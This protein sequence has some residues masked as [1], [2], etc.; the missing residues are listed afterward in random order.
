MTTRAASA[1][2]K[3]GSATRTSVIAAPAAADEE[4]Y[5]N[6][7][8]IDE[9]GENYIDETDYRTEHD[10]W[11]TEAEQPA[12]TD[13][14]LAPQFEYAASKDEENQYQ[15]S[16]KTQRQRQQRGDQPKG[17]G[18]ELRRKGVNQDRPRRV[19]YEDQPEGVNGEE[20]YKRAPQSLSTNNKKQV[21]QLSKPD[22]KLTFNQQFEKNSPVIRRNEHFTPPTARYVH[23]SMH[24]LNDKSDRLEVQLHRFEQKQALGKPL[25]HCEKFT[26]YESNASYESDEQKINTTPREFS[27]FS[28]AEP[29]PQRK[30]PNNRR[31][32]RSKKK[33]QMSVS[34]ARRRER[35]SGEESDQPV[36]HCSKTFNTTS[37]PAYQNEPYSSDSESQVY[38]DTTEDASSSSRV[39]IPTFDGENWI[40]FIVQFETASRLCGWTTEVKRMRLILALREAALK[41]IQSQDIGNLTYKQLVKKLD[42]RFCTTKSRREVM[43]TLLGMKRQ[44]K[45]SILEFADQLRY[46]AKTADFTQEERDT[47]LY[48]AF[49]KGIE[50]DKLTQIEVFNKCLP[51]SFEEA[52]TI[53]MEYE[54]D[55]SITAETRQ[56]DVSTQVNIDSDSTQSTAPEDPKSAPKS[57]YKYNSHYR[58]SQMFLGKGDGVRSAWQA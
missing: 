28:S 35:F 56:Q 2:K 18:S 14:E 7:D 1:L 4:L 38:T 51:L 11:E 50:Y 58:N 15:E 49:M 29:F 42:A 27:N 8:T 5:Y 40:P 32:V 37:T 17:K 3:Q 16:S 30:P 21:Q 34:A 44:P 33:R 41:T 36:K 12:E 57:A 10:D 54:R 26:N 13:A 48:C 45:H 46:A 23:D 53:A 52:V 6:Q 19:N 22:C 31:Q 43:N 20:Q 25:E 55:Y 47:F 9:R 24:K 39:R